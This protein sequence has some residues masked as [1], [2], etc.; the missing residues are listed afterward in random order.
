[1][2]WIKTNYCTFVVVSRVVPGRDIFRSVLDLEFS[3]GAFWKKLKLQAPSKK[4]NSHYFIFKKEFWIHASYSFNEFAGKVELKTAR[5]VFKILSSYRFL[6]KDN[7]EEWKEFLMT[8][9]C[10]L[11]AV[12]SDS[13]TLGYYILQGS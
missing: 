8:A 5:Y 1:M 10:S 3:G 2:A 4:N 9:V 11:G 13:S 6:L 7:L 12:N